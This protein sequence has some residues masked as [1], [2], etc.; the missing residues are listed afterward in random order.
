MACECGIA[1]SDGEL[2]S[3]AGTRGQKLWDTLAYKE[4]EA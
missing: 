3:F 1:F 2:M 4:R